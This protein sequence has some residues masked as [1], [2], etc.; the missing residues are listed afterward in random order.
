MPS[1]TKLEDIGGDTNAA[2]MSAAF[3]YLSHYPKAYEK[4]RCEVRGVFDDVEEI[5]SGTKLSSCTYLRACIEETMRMFPASPGV[6]YREVEEGCWF[7]GEW[8][9]PG[10]DVGTCTFSMMRSTAFQYPF[11]FWPERWIPGSLP[12]AELNAAKLACKPFSQGPRACAGRSVALMSLSIWLARVIYFMDFK[13]AP[14]EA[15][16]VGEGTPAGQKGRQIK[17]EFQ[18]FAHFTAMCEG[19]WIQF[20]MR[21]DGYDAAAT[22][23][24]AHSGASTYDISRGYTAST[25]LAL[26]HYLWKDILGFNL[27]PRVPKP[28]TNSCIAD[29]ATGTGLWLID[30]SQ[31]LS[32]SVKLDGY[33]IALG[34]APPKEWLP[35]NMTLTAW[36]MFLEPPLSI[37]GTYDVVHLRLVSVVIKDNNPEPIVANIKRLL[38]PGGWLQWDDVDIFLASVQHSR[39]GLKTPNLDEWCNW[40]R[41]PKYG[42]PTVPEEH[43]RGKLPKILEAS[44]FESVR[45]EFYDKQMAEKKALAKFNSDQLLLFGEEFANNA[46]RTS[47]DGGKVRTMLSKAFTESQ[48]GAAMLLPPVVFTARKA[49]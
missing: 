13:L 40:M 48:R 30:V 9:S 4:L 41:L 38:K 1:Q 45:V 46:L 6:P 2:T 39:E 43:W 17:E 3:F 19:P 14:G 34:Q 44:G 23:S 16:D 27:H 24:A 18:I 42:Q 33:D 47:A 26:Q 35:P 15:G 21:D 10:I 37:R 12:E 22:E 31:D 29:I 8:I 49:R 5:R 7:D 11:Q 25:R 28:S 36:D 20:K 32:Q